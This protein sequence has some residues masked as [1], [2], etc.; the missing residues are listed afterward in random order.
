MEDDSFNFPQEEFE[1]RVPEI[2]TRWERHFG[3]EGWNFMKEK[4]AGDDFENTPYLDDLTRMIEGSGLT[5]NNIVKH[6]LN[7]TEITSRKP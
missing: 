1:E 7:G 2:M 5:V 3:P 4:L 6:G